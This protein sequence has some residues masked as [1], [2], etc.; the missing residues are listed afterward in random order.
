MLEFGKKKIKKETITYQKSS[1]I[2]FNPWAHAW[3]I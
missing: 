2:G 1:M 3:A